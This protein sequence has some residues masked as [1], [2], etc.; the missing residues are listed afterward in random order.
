LAAAFEIAAVDEHDVHDN[1]AAVP[2]QRVAR[3]L[4]DRRDDSERSVAIRGGAEIQP[5]PRR[6][7]LSIPRV[8]AQTGAR[9]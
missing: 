3:A 4:T 2:L 5:D 6:R 8:D 9:S 7:A 1:T